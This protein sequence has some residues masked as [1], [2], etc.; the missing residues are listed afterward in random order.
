MRGGDWSPETVGT[1][2]ADW[3]WVPCEGWNHQKC[4]DMMRDVGYAQVFTPQNTVG[5]CIQQGG[6][7]SLGY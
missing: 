7:D 3:N 1:W 4:A 6:V 5:E 2:V